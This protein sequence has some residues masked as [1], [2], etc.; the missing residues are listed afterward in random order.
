MRCVV[1]SLGCA[2]C[3]PHLVA[4]D[5]VAETA[6]CEV[7][8]PGPM[9]PTGPPGPPGQ[10]ARLPYRWVDATGAVV[11]ESPDLVWIDPS[12]GYVWKIDHETGAYESG[13]ESAQLRW[14]DNASCQG[15]AW[16]VA[17]NLPRE[18][19]RV[20]GAGSPYLVRPDSVPSESIYADATI[21]VSGTCIA[22]FASFYLS[23]VVGEYTLTSTGLTEPPLSPW[24][25]PLHL[26]P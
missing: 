21:G 2:A 11:T 14:Y 16:F 10:A 1:A 6:D 25:G 3:G 23:D 24:V 12:T 17:L 4:R 15:T 13:P 8:E 19:F 5:D 9:G 20:D 26:E 7:C 22:T 18:P